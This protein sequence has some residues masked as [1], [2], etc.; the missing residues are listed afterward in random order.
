MIST[1]VWLKTYQ[2]PS[3]LL[4]DGAISGV[5]AVLTFLQQITIPR[6]NLYHFTIITIAIIFVIFSTASGALAVAV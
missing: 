5:G 6:I 1:T 2:S 3:S 4:V